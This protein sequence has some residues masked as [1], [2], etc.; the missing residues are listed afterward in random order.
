VL[1]HGTESHREEVAGVEQVV[2]GTHLTHL[3]GNIF[4][5]LSEA[6]Q[7]LQFMEQ[8]D[9]RLLVTDSNRGKITRN[10]IPI[11]DSRHDSYFD[12]R[13]VLQFMRAVTNSAE[14]RYIAHLWQRL[15][16]AGYMQSEVTQS[17]VTWVP[18]PTKKEG[19]MDMLA[20]RHNLGFSTDHVV[21]RGMGLVA[22][23]L[24]SHIEI[25]ADHVPFVATPSA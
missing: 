13:Q 24:L 20:A 12:R 7:L 2:G 16:R 1:P 6:G 4:A 21:T 14:P 11:A 25:R 15:H 3:T 22:V 18:D 5:Q 17:A 8:E 10:G 9:V 23:Q 19:R